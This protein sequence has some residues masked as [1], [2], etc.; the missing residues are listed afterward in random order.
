[1]NLSHVIAQADVIIGSLLSIA[2]LFV[3]YHQIIKHKGE[4]AKDLHV[5]Y[6][7]VKKLANDDIE[8]NYPEIL[9]ILSAITQT[10]LSIAE[11]RW[12]IDEPR[13]FLKLYAYGKL[14]PRYSRIDLSTGEFALTERVNSFKKRMLERCLILAI[15]AAI[16]G[17][18]IFIWYYIVPTG[19]IEYIGTGFLIIYILILAWGVN[20]LFTALA[21]AKQLVGKP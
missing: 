5:R 13:A 17:V 1:M 3:I 4:K 20:Y 10:N 18:V 2:G 11:I 9:I 14:P 7:Q 21:K 12:F 19:T 16:L 15:S 8:A 6:A